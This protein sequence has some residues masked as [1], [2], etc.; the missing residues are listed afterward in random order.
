MEPTTPSNIEKRSAD[1]FEL[2]RNL[3][4]TTFPRKH[5]SFTLLKKNM[6]NFT[7]N[8]MAANKATLTISVGVALSTQYA[9]NDKLLKKAHSLPLQQRLQNH[10]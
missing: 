3:S 9:K 4:L 1:M 10:F 5:F 2:L 7:Y 6:A 8:V